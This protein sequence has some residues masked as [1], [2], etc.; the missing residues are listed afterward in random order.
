MT[1][2]APTI[3][4]LAARLAGTRWQ[5]PASAIA[6]LAATGLAHDH[7]RLGSTGL[8]A[9]VPKQSQLAL[10]PAENL[11]Y[12]AAC[13]RRAAPGGHAPRLA[14]VLDP[15]DDL[16]MGALLVEEI[17][18]APLRLPDGLPALAAALASLHVLPLP[19][20][21][22]RAPLMSPADPLAGTLAEI[23]AQA[24]FLDMAGIVP[25]A[26]SQ[27]DRELSDA[28]A[29]ARS[30]VRPPTALI[31]F[32][33][34]PGNFLQTADGRAVLVDLE[35]ARYGLPGLDLA[36]ATLYTSTTW[37]IATHAEL[38]HDDVAGFYAAWLDA[39]PPAL[40]AAARPWLL[41]LR[42]VMWLWSVTWCAKWRVQSRG[43]GASGSTENWS[44]G[45]S[46]PELM[47]HV[48]GRVADYL[49]AETIAAVRQDWRGDNALTGL[50]G[51]VE[52]PQYATA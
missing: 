8:L 37:D 41:P 1:A 9:R 39:V 6:P 21:A 49:D 7:F 19:A 38:S 24:A 51:P 36:H 31:A 48:A 15:G 25:A 3:G 20:A 35:K 40:A 12:Q 17:D 28:R 43:S 46:A 47:D 2:R 16:P 27:I 23:A 18:G 29:L 5:V 4:V 10:A 52:N 45:L 33:A 22:D 50:L 11:A 32:D 30:R 13:F 42:R 34:H 14:G 26:L 44:A